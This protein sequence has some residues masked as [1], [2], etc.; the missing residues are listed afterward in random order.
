LSVSA[1]SVFDGSQD[2]VI[3]H[4]D[5]V[6]GSS[7][8][9]GSKCRSSSVVEHVNSRFD[10]YPSVFP[11]Q[12]SHDSLLL[13]RLLDAIDVDFLHLHHRLHHVFGRGRIFV[14]EIIEQKMER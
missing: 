5:V 11:L 1:F 13:I 8:A 10:L 7:P 9:S 3:A 4:N 12:C 6:A 14:V 2:W